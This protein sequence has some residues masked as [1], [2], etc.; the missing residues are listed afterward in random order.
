MTKS[1]EQIAQLITILIENNIK[2]SKMYK[3]C[4]KYESSNLNFR[5]KN[6]WE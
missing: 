4:M 3:H 6:I 1:Y 5:L 2:Q